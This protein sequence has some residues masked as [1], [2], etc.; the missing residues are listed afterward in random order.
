M[1]QRRRGVDVWWRVA[2]ATR[3]F[4]R[5]VRGAAWRAAWVLASDLVAHSHSHEGR[6]E[7]ARLAAGLWR[8]FG[9]PMGGRR[10][11]LCCT[12]DVAHDGW[13]GVGGRFVC[14]DCSQ[15][16]LGGALPYGRCVAAYHGRAG[17]PRHSL[18][19]AYRAVVAFKERRAEWPSLAVPLARA[20][21]AS[22]VEVMSSRPLRGEDRASRPLLVPVPSFENRRP[23]VHMLASLAA[24]KL[25][26]VVLGLG[27]LEKTRDFTQ[28]GLSRA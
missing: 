24:I 23:H 4:P 6:D 27:V 20:L 25:P 2:R 22:V 13:V 1:R 26:R 12:D 8:G 10:C 16:T 5:E 17:S 14:L 28:K 3:T 7:L 15:A 19:E 21:A 11:H 9:E 18:G